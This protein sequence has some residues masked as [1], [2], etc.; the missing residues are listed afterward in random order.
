MLCALFVICDNPRNSRG[1]FHWFCGFEGC[2]HWTHLKY[3]CNDKVLKRSDKFYCPCYGLPCKIILKNNLTLISNKLLL[4]F[5]DFVV[6]V[7]V[8]VFNR[9][10]LSWSFLGH[11]HVNLKFICWKFWMEIS[12]FWFDNS[13]KYILCH[14]PQWL[15]FNLRFLFF[16]V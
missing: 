8:S 16:K 10:I 1:V 6:P 7:G 15:K 4:F 2:E 9:S 11:Y 12:A 14:Q 3:C 5:V 13:M